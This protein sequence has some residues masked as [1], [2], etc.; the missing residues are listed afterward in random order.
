MCYR[1]EQL[2]KCHTNVSVN[3]LT[4][5]IITENQDDEIIKLSFTLYFKYVEKFCI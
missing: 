5:E 4:I 3:M 2:D 1:K